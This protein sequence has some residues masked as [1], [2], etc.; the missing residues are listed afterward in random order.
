MLATILHLSNISFEGVD[1]EQ[2]E[3]AS[4][5]DRAVRFFFLIL[6]LASSFVSLLV[7]ELVYSGVFLVH[8]YFFLFFCFCRKR[9]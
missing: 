9:C 8:Y 7:V 5:R 1:H 2:G 4:V 3:V 6:L